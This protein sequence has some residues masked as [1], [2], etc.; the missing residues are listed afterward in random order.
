MSEKKLRL[1]GRSA[2]ILALALILLLILALFTA[3][4]TARYRSRL[5]V[6]GTIQ[7]INRQASAFSMTNGKIEPVQLDPAGDGT[8]SVNDAKNRAS[9]DEFEFFLIPGATVR[10]SPVIQIAEKTEIS[11]YL[12]VEV[13]ATKG[14]RFHVDSEN[15]ECLE[16]LTGLNGGLMYVY[17][18]TLD[19]GSSLIP[20]DASIGISRTPSKGEQFMFYAYLIQRLD[21]SSAADT[22]VSAVGQE[23]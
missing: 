22:F 23:A 10:V 13:C 17:R 16:D 7:Y 8:M 4:G 2:R 18:G 1:G 20:V 9:S 6:E 12:Y 11:S 19:E 21:D 14:L 3:A 15:W 5:T